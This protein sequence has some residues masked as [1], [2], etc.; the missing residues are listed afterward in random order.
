MNRLYFGD[1]AQEEGLSRE[2]HLQ[3]NG[4]GVNRS[5]VATLIWGVENQKAAGGVLL[6][7]EKRSKQMRTEATD[8]ARYASNLW[9]D[10]DYPRIQILTVERLLNGSERIDAPLQIGPLAMVAREQKQH[11]QAQVL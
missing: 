5:D 9:H 6:A 2:N 8:A 4:D 11:E 7:L 3:V 10:I 1:R